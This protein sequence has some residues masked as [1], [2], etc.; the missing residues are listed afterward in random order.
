M[1]NG[2][3]LVGL[4][5]ALLP[6]VMALFKRL[7]LDQKVQDLIIL[8]ALVGIAGAVAFASGEVSVG[9]CAGLD[10]EGC[11]GVIYKYV[12]LVVTNAFVFYKMLWKPTGID[13]KIAGK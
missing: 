12:G 4:L 8:L 2:D 7:G 5:G 6:L 11:F 1:G 9:G 13:D 10:L 3:W